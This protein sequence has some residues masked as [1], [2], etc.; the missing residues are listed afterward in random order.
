MLNLAGALS[1][2][3]DSRDTPQQ[4]KEFTQVVTKPIIDTKEVFLFE[5]RLGEPWNL[6]LKRIAQYNQMAANFVGK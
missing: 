6:T 4:C 5:K 3:A 2:F 1:F